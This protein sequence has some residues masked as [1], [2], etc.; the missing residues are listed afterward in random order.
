M[1]ILISPAKTFAKTIT[2]F[3]TTPIFEN[4]ALSM[5]S[6]LSKIS[7]ANLISKMHISKDL[8]QKV[9]HDYLYFGK[10]KSSAIYAYDGYAFKGFDVLHMDQKTLSYL[11]E[12]LYILSGLYGIVR[13]YDGISVYRLEMKDHILKNLY[14]FW[15]PKI[16]KYLLETHRDELFINLAS[17]EYSKVIDPKIPVLSISFYQRKDS[18]LKAISM[19]VKLMRGK[20]ANYLLTHQIN[21][22]ELIKDISIDGYLFDAKQ[23]TE[24]EYVFIK[25][26]NA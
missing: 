1:I 16:K 8:A 15:K 18:K 17:S 20:M 24:N 12:H 13:P 10:V 22:K 6:K 21:N 5:I 9:K 26:I 19:H 4:D 25:E 7:V 11:N 23:S 14:H 2:S 3:E